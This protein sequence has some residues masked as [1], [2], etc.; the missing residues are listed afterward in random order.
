[1]RTRIDPA[2]IPADL[3]PRAERF[4]ELL[5]EKLL[6]AFPSFEIEAVLSAAPAHLERSVFLRM[7]VRDNDGVMRWDGERCLTS[8]NL[9]VT[10]VALRRL[11]NRIVYR[12]ADHLSEVVGENLNRMR[13]RLLRHEPVTAE[14]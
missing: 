9:E 1:M 4:A 7:G 2:N 11:A 8:D 6:A 3:L 5:D 14:A 10:D 12:F 13:E